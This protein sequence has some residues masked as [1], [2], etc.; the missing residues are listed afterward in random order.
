M[1]ERQRRNDERSEAI[2]QA[3]TSAEGNVDP[4]TQTALETL[5]GRVDELDSRAR[6]AVQDLTSSQK[7]VQA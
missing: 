6:K 3:C 4:A 1:H 2:Y 7:N 5:A